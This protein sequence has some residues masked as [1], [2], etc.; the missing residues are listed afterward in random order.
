MLLIIAAFVG[1]YFATLPTP[2]VHH[3]VSN[4]VIENSP[5]VVTPNQT[6][7]TDVR[8]IDA[9]ILLD[10]RYATNNNFIKRQVYPSDRCLLRD[11]V[12]RQLA[13]VQTELRSQNLGLKVYDC[14]RPLSVQKLMWQ[15]VADERFV[16]NPAKGSRHNRGAAVDLTLVDRSGKDLPMPTDFD[17]FSDRAFR[18]SP[19]VPAVARANSQRLEAAMTKY[20]FL[21]LPTEW[22]HFDGPN[23]AQFEISDV[24][25]ETV[26]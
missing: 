10:M 1:F 6:G 19:D 3:P 11:S 18:N 12:A 21:P 5:A 15:I 8:A 22:W 16:A 20:G 25:L 7:F 13:K 4:P 17:D 23:W 26:P 24:A 9:S 2:P 14:Y